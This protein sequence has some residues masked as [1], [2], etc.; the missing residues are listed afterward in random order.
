MIQI[1]RMDAYDR[2]VRDEV[3]DLFIEGFYNKLH[4]FTKDPQR[5]KV[6]FRD[7]LRADMF[8]VAELDGQIAGILAVSSSTRRAVVADKGSLRRG[9]G[10][11]MGTVAYSALKND[12]N[13]PLPYDDETGYIEWVATAEQARGQ[14]VSTA[15][16]QH[17]LQQLPYTTFV[18]EVLDFNENAHRLYLKLGFEEYDRRPAKGGE[19]KV[20]KERIFMRRRSG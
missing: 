15:L 19:K 20:F 10:F 5:L 12:F 18:L 11:L 1:R 2:E 17:V 8:Y 14:G 6:A 4:F 13:S 7:E 9:L 16:F 3:A